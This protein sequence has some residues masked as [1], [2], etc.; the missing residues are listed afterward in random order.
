MRGYGSNL[1]LITGTSGAETETEVPEKPSPKKRKE[2][3]EKPAPEK[4]NPTV[5]KKTS[6]EKQPIDDSTK[7]ISSLISQ[8]GPKATQQEL[9]LLKNTLL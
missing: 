9:D 8:S 6:P 1:A 7:V 2:A 3:P 4:K 5:S